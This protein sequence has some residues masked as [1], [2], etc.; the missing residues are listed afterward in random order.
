MKITLTFII[1][2]LFTVQMYAQFHTLTLPQASP[3]VTETQQ[4]GVTNITLNYSSPRLNG[5]D[6]WNM[7]SV[8]PQKGDPIPWRAGANMATTIEFNT[9]VL[10]EGNALKKGIYGIHIV[11]NANNFTIYFA[12]AYDQ[13]GSYYVDLEKDISLKVNVNAKSCATSE[14][15]D[16]KFINRSENSLTLALEWGEKQIPIEIAVDL[17]NTVVNSLRN[18]L[19]GINTYHWQAWHD[20]AMWCL[21]H[22]TNLE[23]A[24]TWAERSINGGYNGFAANKNVTNVSTHLRLLKKLNKTNTYNE[25]LNSAMELQ[26]DAYEANNFSI[27]LLRMGEYEKSKIYLNNKIKEYPNQWSLILNRGIANYYLNANK[28]AVNDV[29]S[30]IDKAPSQYHNRLQ[31][32]ISEFKSKTY[33]LPTFE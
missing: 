12:H 20:A 13:W 29:E 16:F 3:K 14:Q 19:R 11:P 8:I 2:S 9:D 15:L 10:I 27:F 23:E 4:L 32:I 30:I 5:R 18:E 24:L 21:E 28:K 22:N 7:P 17:N 6:V 31:E 25:S 1:A 33:N 26:V